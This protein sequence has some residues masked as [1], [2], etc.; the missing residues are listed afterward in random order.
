MA[1]DSSRG[2]WDSRRTSAIKN[3]VGFV[4]V[5]SARAETRRAQRARTVGL[6]LAL[7]A[8][9]II[10][11]SGPTTNL[12]F[13]NGATT[14][15]VLVFAGIFGIAT[16][17]FARPLL[18][19]LRKKL[20]A[21][22]EEPNLVVNR[23]SF[24]QW[25]RSG[26][27]SRAGLQHVLL[28][29]FF[30]GTNGICFTFG[31]NLTSVA[32][33]LAFATLAP[34]W[35]ALLSWLVLKTRLRRR[36]VVAMVGAVIGGLIICYGKGLS[37]D[38]SA[39]IDRREGYG[40][41][42]GVCTGLTL[43]GLFT[44]IGSAARNTPDTEMLNGNVLGFVLQCVVGMIIDAA[45]RATGEP[46]ALWNPS[47]RAFAWLAANAVL[48][49]VAY[50]LSALAGGIIS[51]SEVSLAFQF[52]LVLGTLY[53]FFFIG[54]MPSTFTCIGGGLILAL[55]ITHEFLTYLEH[56]R[57]LPDL[58][59]LSGSTLDLIALAGESEPKPVVEAASLRAVN[60]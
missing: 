48:V 37:F 40:L 7:M 50:N 2:G 55:V 5:V 18:G 23:L 11:L 10:S 15:S 41:A 32:N 43:A 59:R 12:A 9:A 24:A 19:L 31:F 44:T 49:A 1:N 13:R 39:S 35:T 33:V 57:Q 4:S 16:M 56:R 54:Q 6:A 36:T 60:I 14:A 22:D 34:V 26:L 30:A 58:G 8:V 53:T 3:G 25:L 29:G 52:E 47:P 38:G 28:A 51:P 17:I 27:P 21:G 20:L 42:F 45:T 46:S